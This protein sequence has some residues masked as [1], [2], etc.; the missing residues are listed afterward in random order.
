[1]I[2]VISQINWQAM[3]AAPKGHSEFAVTKQPQVHGYY[4]IMKVS[5]P[6]LKA[7]EY[8]FTQEEGLDSTLLMVSWSGFSILSRDVPS[9]NS[10][11][12]MFFDDRSSMTSGI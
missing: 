3:L 2:E 11:V 5:S 1:M 7:Q 10:V 9:I 8:F 4:N 6:V 12:R